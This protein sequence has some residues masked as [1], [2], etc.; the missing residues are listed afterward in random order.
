MNN[1]PLLGRAETELAGEIQAR[2]LDFCWEQW[3]QMGV[4]GAAP[5]A[6]AVRAQDPEALMVLTLEIARAEPRLFDEMLDWVALNER[7]LSLRR[8]RGMCV[9]MEDSQLVSAAAR[10]LGWERPRDDP[11]AELRNLFALGGPVPEQDPSFASAGLLRPLLERSGRSITPD[12]AMPINLS[13]RLRAILG[14]GIRAEVLRIMLTAQTGLL[15]AAS[16][17]RTSTYAKRNVHDALGWLAEASVIDAALIGGE[18]RYTIDPSRWAPL[19]DLTVEELPSHVEWGTIFGVLRIVL[20]WARRPETAQASDYIVSSQ[21][22][23]LLEEIAPHLAY[24][25]LPVQKPRLAEGALDA[26]AVSVRR[27]LDACTSG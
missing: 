1:I 24:A 6:A 8:L 11:P 13:L 15:P 22:R 12:L 10:W 4:S 17:A 9:D 26:L 19:L 2:L 7:L 25:G 16:L 20:R 27:A 21:A 14:V 5:R 23:Q 18:F 3:A